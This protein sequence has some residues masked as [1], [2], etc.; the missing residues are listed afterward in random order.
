MNRAMKFQS[1]SPGDLPFE[2][3]LGPH[4]STVHMKRVPERSKEMNPRSQEAHRPPVSL[5]HVHPLLDS[6]LLSPDEYS[7]ANPPK[8]PAPSR[9]PSL[10]HQRILPKRYKES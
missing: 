6:Q 2:V 10:A 9:T 3:N 4:L 7:E 8:H 1:Q 5:T